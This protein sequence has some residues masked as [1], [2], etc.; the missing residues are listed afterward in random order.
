M[1]MTM[2]GLQGLAS[3]YG[4]DSA[5]TLSAK[6]TLL[7][8]LEAFTGMLDKHFDGDVTFQVGC[9]EVCRREGAS[10]VQL[11][12]ALSLSVPLPAFALQQCFH[13]VRA[14]PPLLLF[15]PLLMCVCVC[16]CVCRISYIQ[17]ALFDSAPS[18]QDTASALA[19]K[20]QRHAR[21]LQSECTRPSR[22]CLDC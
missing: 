9:C 4:K 11:G 22:R 5:E 15:L 7:A 6:S 1:D 19:W 10:F 2:L 16:V 21:V 20:Q 13:F 12:P 3:K 14:L 17:V 18:A 8:V